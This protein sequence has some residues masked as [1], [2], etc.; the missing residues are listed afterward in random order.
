M[1]IN[2]SFKMFAVMTQIYI[3]IYSGNKEIIRD[4][5][6][7]LLFICISNAF[8]LMANCLFNGLVHDESDKLLS[9]LDNIS[10]SKCPKDEDLF[11]ETLL[12]MSISRN[13][14]FGFSI[15]G[16][17][18]LRKTTLTS[19]SYPFLA[20]VHPPF[21]QVRPKVDIYYRKCQCRASSV[22]R[23]TCRGRC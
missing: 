9:S 6:G 5:V 18:S 10:I 17:M 3:F 14:K 13:L 20:T 21:V 15:A 4:F 7:T 1:L 2:I 16:F 11:N 12:F 22:L 19:V 8:K 23:G